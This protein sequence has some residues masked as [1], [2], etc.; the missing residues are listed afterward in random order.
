MQ[1]DIPFISLFIWHM[2]LTLHLRKPRGVAWHIPDAS[3]RPMQAVATLQRA[4][5]ILEHAPLGQLD[6]HGGGALGRWEGG[7]LVCVWGEGGL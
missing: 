1:V 6:R 3:E 5:P 7:E 2:N 4:Q